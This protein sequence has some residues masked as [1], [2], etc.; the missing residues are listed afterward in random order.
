MLILKKY[1]FE[2]NY[3]KCQFLKRKVEYLG[4]I[5]SEDEMSL[6]DRH[7]EVVKN[8]PQPKTVRAVQAFLGLTILEN[9]LRVT[10]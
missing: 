3:K 9:L 1:N 5:V 8:F 10:P 7:I 2:L 6:S 4:Y